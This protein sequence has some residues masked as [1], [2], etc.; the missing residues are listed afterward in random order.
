DELTGLPNRRALNSTGDGALARSSRS[1]QELAMLLIDLDGF[2]GVNDTLGHPA[3]DALLQEV[4][5]RL[6]Q[7]TR[8]GETLARLGGDEFAVIAENL[9]DEE[10]ARP[11]AERLIEAL[12][13]PIQID[14]QWLA[15]GTSIGFTVTSDQ[16]RPTSTADLLKQADI[17]LYEAKRQGRGRAL[18][19]TPAMAVEAEVEARLLRE[20]Q[21]GFDRGEFHLVFQPLVSTND[22]ETVAFES[23]MRWHSPTLG[24]V[25][26]VTFIPI[27][28]RTGAI[29]EMGRWALAESCR[30]L[31]EWNALYPD[32]RLSVSVNISLQQITDDG[33]PALVKRVLD[34]TGVSPHQLQLEVTESMLAINPH[35]VTAPLQ[36][37]RDLGVRVALDDF[38]TGYSSMA[39][40]QTLPVDCIKIDRAFIDRLKLLGDRQAALV[41][42]AIVDLGRAL[43]VVVVAEGV[44]NQGQLDALLLQKVEV[45]QGFLFAYPLE[46]EQVGDF[47]DRQHLLSDS[48]QPSTS[49]SGNP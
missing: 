30:R 5:R 7:S 26:P 46:P 47:L 12:R 32:R 11:L 17:A 18:S 1:S 41:I 24:I 21:L 34:D 31:A 15:V 20:V 42:Q 8:A 38:G 23:L 36:A 27:A 9:T 6:Q 28:E 35:K 19:F 4:A 22:S 43:D 2:K 16:N 44:E 48:T 13:P 3:G 25:S 45:A 10:A 37:L 40:L 29:I 39:H 33:L 14:G 49:T